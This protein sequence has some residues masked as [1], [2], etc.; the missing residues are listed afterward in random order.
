[1]AYSDGFFLEESHPMSAD[2]HT[3]QNHS[4]FYG[5]AQ[6]FRRICIT[7]VSWYSILKGCIWTYMASVCGS[8]Y[9]RMSLYAPGVPPV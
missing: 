9:A 3:G 4:H 5:N 1:M 7:I 6:P 8:L 2:T